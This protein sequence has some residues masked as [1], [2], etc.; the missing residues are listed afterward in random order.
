MAFSRKLNDKQRAHILARRALLAQQLSS[1]PRVQ[2]YIAHGSRKPG[3]NHIA[4]CALRKGGHAP[5]TGGERRLSSFGKKARAAYYRESKR[6]GTWVKYERGKMKL[7]ISES[8]KERIWA[9]L[10]P[11]RVRALTG[12]PQSIVALLG[13][14]GKTMCNVMSKQVP[15]GEGELRKMFRFAVRMSR[16]G[17]VEHFDG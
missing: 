7:G 12:N 11:L 17:A 5:P 16:S 15:H 6:A 9:A 13:A 14:V 10:A 4:W 8:E 2:V 1:R 3:Q